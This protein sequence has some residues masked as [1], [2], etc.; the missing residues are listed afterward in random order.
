MRWWYLAGIVGAVALTQS[1]LAEHLVNQQTIQ[2]SP[3]STLAV[4]L[5]SASL[6]KGKILEWGTGIVAG[7]SGVGVLGLFSKSF[8]NAYSE[9][10]FL[11]TAAVTGLVTKAV[12]S[13]GSVVRGLSEKTGPKGSKPD[14]S[15]P[16]SGINPTEPISRTHS[17][18]PSTGP[19]TAATHTSRTV[20]TSGTTG[21]VHR[22]KTSTIANAMQ[23]LKG[24]KTEESGPT[25]TATH[26]RR[27]VIKNVGGY[28]IAVEE[29]LRE[30][31][32]KS[33]RKTTTNT[34]IGTVHGGA[35]VGDKKA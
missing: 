20:D 6:M 11:G 8:V 2:N 35:D 10:R 18:V 29:P 12:G 25:A 9:L 15:S 19:E 13:A 5:I 16:S 23:E 31:Q 33:R 27:K 30:E 17:K 26:G 34:A 24:A 4:S 7:L 21:A 32:P 28:N 22:D 1:A 14:S 3:Y